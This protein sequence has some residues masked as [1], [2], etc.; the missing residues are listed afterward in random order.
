M[1]TF[2]LI[3]F[4]ATELDVIAGIRQFRMKRHR[5]TTRGFVSRAKLDHVLM[6]R[7]L[8]YLIL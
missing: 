2:A 1:S 3:E 6:S 8:S 7:P 4:M 5:E